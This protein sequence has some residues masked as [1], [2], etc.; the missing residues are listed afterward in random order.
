[1]LN[2]VV[3]GPR[4]DGEL[5]RA[6]LGGLP[7]IQEWN[8]HLI[9]SAAVA[10]DKREA[11]L[12]GGGSNDQIGLREGVPDLAAF[13]NQQAPFQHDILG[14]RKNATVEHG[15]DDLVEPAVDSNPSSRLIDQLD[16]KSQ[17]GKRHDADISSSSGLASRKASTL[18]LGLGRR[19]SER[20]LVS[21]SQA[22]S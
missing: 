10:C 17:F 21:S 16:S 19:N 14:D 9:E 2:G 11:M 8:A 1:M 3:S 4:Q 6:R 5:A 7:R 15:P 18:R 13:L 20:M 22:I 12:D